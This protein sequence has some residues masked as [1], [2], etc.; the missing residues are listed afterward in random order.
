[1]DC[2]ITFSGE[3][4]EAECPKCGIFCAKEDDANYLHGIIILMWS[5]FVALLFFLFIN[6][7][8]SLS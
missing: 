1:M 6:M 5:L 3:G 8:R 2:E 7:M 4:A